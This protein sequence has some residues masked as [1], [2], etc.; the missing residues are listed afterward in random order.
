MSHYEQRLE[1]DLTA[2]RQRIAQI[3]AWVLEAQG[4]AVHALL[5]GDRQLAN[6][7]ILGDLGINREIRAADQDCHTFVARHLPSAGHLRFVSSVLRLNIA[8]E[9]IGDYAV[10]V[11]RSA[12]QL[13]ADLPP[14]LARDLELMASQSQNALQQ[15]LD[16]WNAG[17]AELA[18]G[19]IGMV[20]QVSSASDKVFDD[21]TRDELHGEMPQRDL[22]NLLLVFHRLGRVA[23]QAKNIC[24]ETIFAA[25]GETKAPK[26]YRVLFVDPGDQGLTQIAAAYARKA[27]PQSG[28]YES[29]GWQPAADIDPRAQRFLER[30]GLDQGHF[31]P[32]P[33][34]PLHEDLAHYHV[35]VSLGGGLLPHIPEIPYHTTVLEWDVAVDFESLDQERL[36][37]SLEAA[38]KDLVGRIGE[39]METLRGAGAC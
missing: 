11:C 6:Q 38:F 24:E 14:V 18:R 16:A 33:L 28:T 34:S 8:L 7:T 5:R 20:R 2:L 19:A 39:L 23:S 10:T 36:E 30:H 1:A 25:T 26:V 13:S 3:G 9:R 32:R 27:F 21:L 12:V 35:I 31:E 17:N 22:L 37:H 15:A 29:A 4:N